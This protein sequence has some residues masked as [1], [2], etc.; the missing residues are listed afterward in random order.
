MSE[1]RF[2]LHPPPRPLLPAAAA[3]I[4]FGHPLTQAAW[5][6]ATLFGIL[7]WHGASSPDFASLIASR[8]STETTG[9][10]E[11]VE[12]TESWSS[13]SIID[14]AQTLVAIHYRYDS[15]QGSHR[16]VAYG[17]DPTWNPGE[18]IPVAYVNHRP[19]WSR[20]PGLRAGKHK[21]KE[22]LFAIPAMIFLLA[23]LWM[24]WRGLG[25]AQLLHHGVIEGGR[26]S[27]RRSP[28]VRSY[29]LVIAADGRDY[30]LEETEQLTAWTDSAVIQ[31]I[32]LVDPVSRNAINLDQV[33][34]NPTVQRDG[35]VRLQPQR[36]GFLPLIFPGASVLVH[37]I[38]TIALIAWV[39]TGNWP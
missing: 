9:V 6:F 10:V 1:V 21:A 24:S 34:G 35:V 36:P 29:E 18:P 19:G 31:P 12:K 15:P 33:P 32:R 38:G 25:I 28:R 4:V 22:L 26:S 11:Q 13:Q 30:E 14:G 37:V 5:C 2:V 17:I 3:W 8:P 20:V 7:F 27:Q 16:G 23:S 39:A